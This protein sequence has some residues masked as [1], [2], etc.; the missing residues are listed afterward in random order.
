M[1]HTIAIQND[2]SAPE[3][4]LLHA[5]DWSNWDE[6]RVIAYC[7]QTWTGMRNTAIAFLQTAFR[8]LI[9]LIV[10]YATV[11]GVSRSSSVLRA[12]TWREMAL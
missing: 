5:A 10:N 12:W 9:I 3:A 11:R 4:E 6:I 1:C 8:L 7:W 2:N